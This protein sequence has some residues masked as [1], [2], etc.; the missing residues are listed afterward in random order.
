MRLVTYSRNGAAC[1]GALL[2]EQ[3]VDIQAAYQAMRIAS[4]IQESL[5]SM[6]TLLA[7]GD[8]AMSAARAAVEFA[9]TQA[10]R[11]DLF[12]KLEDVTLLPPLPN[13][14]KLIC[15][16]GNF[17]AVGKLSAPEF[18]TIFL[19][20][21]STITGPGMPV[22]IPV[23]ASS[24]AYEVELAVVIGRRAHN[25]I[26]EDTSA[27]IAGYTLANDIGDRLLEKRTSQWISGKMFDSFT[28]MGPAILTPDEIDNPHN[29]RMQTHVNDQQVQAG[30][31]GQMFFNVEYLVRYLSTLTTLEPGDLI[32]TGSPKMMGTEVGPSV[33]IK[34]GDTVR[35]S[36][37]CL[38]ELVNLIREDGR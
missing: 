32:L 14:G 24:V 19:K 29:L 1:L 23:I 6:L 35:I 10:G 34:P 25:L 8:E 33:S 2:G 4:G 17:P 30:N 27:Y 13:P 36:I 7:A 38:G 28:P 12:S 18:P 22:W 20:P 21:A 3:V 16:A 26:E 5:A 11:Q 37:D 31:T 9:G 15:I